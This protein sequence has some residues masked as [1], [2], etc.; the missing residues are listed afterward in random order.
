MMKTKNLK[1]KLSTLAL[2]IALTGCGADLEPVDGDSIGPRFAAPQFTSTAAET[3]A[4]VDEEYSHTFT[5]S[6]AD[7]DDLT[8]SAI[9]PDGSW[10]NFDASTGILSGT[11][12]SGDKGLSSVS[13]N[14]TD[15]MFTS[16]ENA[17]IS[18]GSG[19]KPDTA[20]NLLINS[21]FDAG[22]TDWSEAP[23]V[24]V[25]EQLVPE[26]T[27]N[28]Y[29][30][31]LSHA[32]TL[33]AGEVYTLSYDAKASTARPMTAGFGLSGAPYTNNIHIVELTT[34]WAPYELMVASDAGGDQS[35]TIFDMG[36]LIIGDI[37]LRNISLLDSAGTDIFATTEPVGSYY[38][39]SIATAGNPWDVNLSQVMTI[40]P[41]EIYVVE[42]K[43]KASVARNIT[44][45]VGLAHDP[46]D[47]AVESVAITTEW[48]TYFIV[49]P[50]TGFGDDNSRVLFD[51]GDEV[52]D[53]SIDDIT[54]GIAQ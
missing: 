7:G 44:V 21:S 23:G 13:V 28:V 19:G 11:P 43:A 14:V 16:S 10:L 45:G 35:R 15:G 17:L 29:D 37:E 47:N 31:N 3:A 33:V 53:V 4:A 9:L 27:E 1:I 46:W 42:F 34:E 5:A 50:A 26:P 49:V 41:D 18:V 2:A 30:I 20:G 12:G 48:V 54:V 22:L 52:G 38:E 24:S 36:G 40:I 39:A 8:L 32:L 25:Y 51:M 6:D